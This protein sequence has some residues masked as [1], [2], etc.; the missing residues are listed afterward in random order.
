MAT[1]MTVDDAI[2]RMYKHFIIDMSAASGFD[3]CTLSRLR[4]GIY[5]RNRLKKY[6]NLLNFLYYDNETEKG[7]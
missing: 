6:I 7:I 5:S 1:K 3:N 2:E 4:S